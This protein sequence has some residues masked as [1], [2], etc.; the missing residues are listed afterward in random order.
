VSIALYASWWARSAGCR[1]TWSRS[2]RAPAIARD[3]ELEEHA[4]GG[5][6]DPAASLL[7][8][9]PARG[10]VDVGRGHHARGAS[11]PNSGTW[12]PN[13]F[14]R[15]RRG[16][17]SWMRLG[18]HVHDD[19]PAPV[20]GR[21]R[22]AEAVPQRL[23]VRHEPAERVEHEREPDR[24]PHTP[25]ER[26]QHRLDRRDDRVRIEQAHAEVHDPDGLPLD[27]LDE[28]VPLTPEEL[29]RFG[30]GLDGQQIRVVQVRDELDDLG[31]RGRAVGVLLHGD[32]PRLLDRAHA[33]EQADD[34]MRDGAEPVELVGGGVVDDVPAPT[35]IALA[36]DLH[37]RAQPGRHC[38]DAVPEG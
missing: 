12:P 34:L 32:L 2:R 7:V 23:A 9:R 20:A 5:D 24:Q 3:G 22:I 11:K 35:A 25:D 29:L 28:P 37:V 30:R 13:R 10:G 16:R 27:L 14:C 38:T 6:G 18:D 36:R 19:Q 17:V 1:P 33:V 4:A 15:P 26:A 31:L 21:D 8:E